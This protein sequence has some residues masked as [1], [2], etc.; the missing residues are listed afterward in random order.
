M[1]R[2]IRLSRIV[3]LTSILAINPVVGVAAGGDGEVP[4]EPWHVPTGLTEAPMLAQL[5]ATGDLAPVDERLPTAPSVLHGS[6]IGRYG[7]TAHVLNIATDPLNDFIDQPQLGRYLFQLTPKSNVVGDIAKSFEITDDHTLTIKLREG[8]YWSDG[9]PFDA[10]DIVYRFNELKVGESSSRIYNLFPEVTRADKID[11]YTVAFTTNEAASDLPRKLATWAGGNWTAFAPEHYYSNLDMST[12]A[13]QHG[14]GSALEA[15]VSINHGELG[16]T[17]IE[18]PT[19]HPWR[20][21]SADAKQ[22]SMTRNPYYAR[23]DSAGNQLPYI[24]HIVAR[25]VPDRDTYTL[26]VLTGEADIAYSHTNFADLMLLQKTA[27]S[28]AYDVTLI[29]GARFALLFNFEHPN[30]D[31]PAL[32]G[33]ERFRQA[34]SL[35]IDRDEIAGHGYLMPSTPNEYTDYDLIKANALLDEVDPSGHRLRSGSQFAVNLVCRNF[36][37]REHEAVLDAIRDGW[38]QVG[39]RVSFDCSELGP[40]QS[41]NEQPNVANI[42]AAIVIDDY[43]DWW[44]SIL[45]EPS[46]DRPPVIDV[47]AIAHPFVAANQIQNV[48]GSFAFGMPIRA[49]LSHFG[50]QLFFRE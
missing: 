21:D 4:D 44:S 41:N 20:L 40:S 30:G 19:L 3:A 8:M 35:S 1:G 36:Q 17:F 25:V 23:V 14:F 39:I 26:K 50:E 28:G 49:S 42:V 38:A 11:D 48:P 16:R 34:L 43:T 27:D 29:S 32:Y 33:D 18:K 12:F 24:D 15:L 31:R 9:D 10:D 47:V 5:V 7:G 46:V 22:R 13:E 2:K 37:F 6:P 45:D